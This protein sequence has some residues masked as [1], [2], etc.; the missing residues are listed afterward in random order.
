MFWFQTNVK[1]GL[2]WYHLLDIPTIFLSFHKFYLVYFK[3]KD[4][5]GVERIQLVSKGGVNAT[6]GIYQEN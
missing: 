2:V 4:V 1:G 5:V 3:C 6:L